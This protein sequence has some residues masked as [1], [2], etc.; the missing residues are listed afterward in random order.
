MALNSV[1]ISPMQTTNQA[2]LFST[3]SDGLVQGF[4]YDDPSS[5]NWLTNT[6]LAATETL[7]MIGGVA[8]SHF[9]PLATGGGTI[10]ARATNLAGITGFSV[11]NQ[12]HA[13]IMTSTSQLPVWLPGMTV[14]TVRFGTNARVAVAIDPALANLDGGLITQQV[15]WDFV[16][17]RLVPYQAGTGA[18]AT[19]AV[20]WNTGIVTVTTASAHNLAPGN[21][22]T[23]S[24]IVPAAYNGSYTVIATPS[25]TQFTYA[26]PNGG[27]SPGTVTTQGSLAAAGGAL[28][29]RVLAVLT[30]NCIVANPNYATGP[31]SWNYNGAAAVILI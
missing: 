14:P 31:N 21:D 29:V 22:V 24:G 11:Y 5:R 12:G 4:M 1:A 23:L 3:V 30:T 2:G 16:N 6:T 25:G 13:A 18:I 27:V 20:T 7:P 9:I 10:S 17:Q 15:S 19:T 28:P 8:I 26:L